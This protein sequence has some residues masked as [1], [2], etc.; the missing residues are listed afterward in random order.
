MHGCGKVNFKG[1]N[2][3]GGG[4]HYSPPTNASILAGIN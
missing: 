3:I 1:I 2:T 4:E